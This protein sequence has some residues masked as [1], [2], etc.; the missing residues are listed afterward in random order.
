MDKASFRLMLNSFCRK[1]KI[2]KLTSNDFQNI[3]WHLIVINDESLNL[4]E[5]HSNVNT[6]DKI[7]HHRGLEGSSSEDISSD[8]DHGPSPCIPQK[9]DS[10]QAYKQNP[11]FIA[12]LRKKLHDESPKS[13]VFS[14]RGQQ[15]TSNS[16]FKIS[17]PQIP[18]VLKTNSVS[19]P[20]LNQSAETTTKD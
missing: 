16:N 3:I 20:K 7:L 6:I 19:N 15:H 10:T 4:T 17:T 8:S 14:P 9:V 2:P 1:N 5:I 13:N 12:N 11:K 18:L